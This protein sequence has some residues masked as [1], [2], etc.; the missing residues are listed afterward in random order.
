M[1]TRNGHR[2]SLGTCI[3]KRR[4]IFELSVAQYSPPITRQIHHYQD[5]LIQKDTHYR[6]LNSRSKQQ[7]RLLIDYNCIYSTKQSML[8]HQQGSNF[9]SISISNQISHLHTHKNFHKQSNLCCAQNQVLT[10]LKIM[11]D[12]TPSVILI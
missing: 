6:N 7:R 9:I 3:W 2:E 1:A 10:A 11:S 12:C 4:N 5:I 8:H